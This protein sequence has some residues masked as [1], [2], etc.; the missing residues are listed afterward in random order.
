MRHGRKSGAGST[1]YI[2]II[3]LV[4]IAAIAVIGLFGAD[5]KNSFMRSGEPLQ[6][7]GEGVVDL[8]YVTNARDMGDFIGSGEAAAGAGASVLHDGPDLHN[9]ASVAYSSSRREARLRARQAAELARI[10]AKIDGAK[11]A[12]D[13]NILMLRDVYGIHLHQNAEA[14][15]AGYSWV[16]NNIKVAP[17]KHFTADDRDWTEAEADIVWDTLSELPQVYQD[18]VEGYEFARTDNLESYVRKKKNGDTYTSK[19]YGLKYK[20]LIV[21]DTSA[22]TKEKLHRSSNEERFT[23]TIVH[24]MTHA[25]QDD[26]DVVDNYVTYWEGKGYTFDYDDDGWS[27]TDSGGLNEGPG[28]TGYALS[29]GPKEHMAETAMFYV[30]DPETLLKKDPDG[31]NWVKDNLFG[32]KKFTKKRSNKK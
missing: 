16:E 21:I 19:P 30:I 1:E 18:A 24:E 28:V 32:G 22:Y 10:G 11:P 12:S 25:V 29:G 15:A 31:Y 5:I 13:D 26:P 4:A 6:G 20:K 7:E 2:I 17:G 3:A 14:A 9:H 23:S 27:F 8:A